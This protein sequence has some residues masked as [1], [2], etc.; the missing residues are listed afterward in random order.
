MTGVIE[1]TDDAA[2]PAKRPT[3]QEDRLPS[4]WRNMPRRLAML[5]AGGTE[6]FWPFTDITVRFFVAAWFFSSGLVKAA[7][8][9]MALYLVANEYPVSWMTPQSAA[10]TGIS[11]ELLG[12]FLLLAGLFTRPAAIAL[13]SLT[14]VAQ[15]Y[16]VPTTTNIMVVVILLWYAVNGPALFAIDR[17]LAPRLRRSF[18]PIGPSIVS[19]GEWLRENA[20]HAVMSLTR[21]WLA[22][23]LLTYAGVIDPSIAIRTWLPVTIF[24]GF[25]DWLAL[26]AAA[27]LVAGL[28]AGLVSYALFFLIGYFMI[29][30][31]HPDV[32]LFPFLLLAI[33]E[34]KGAGYLSLDRL[35]WGWVERNILTD[36]P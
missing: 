14:V 19:A 15:I 13:A 21:V 24:A 27:L 18:L 28:A 2:L 20:S 31:V 8:W 32:T 25:P 36:S 7:D 23:A 6:L 10:I 33:Y 5:Y 3:T 17:A 26:G 1:S 30:G 11:I 34:A 4:F 22:A 9:E 16:Y 29:V 12:A 35:I